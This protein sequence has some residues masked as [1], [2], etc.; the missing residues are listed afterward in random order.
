MSS[1]DDITPYGLELPV[2][3]RLQQRGSGEPQ[4][5]WESRKVLKVLNQPLGYRSQSLR[6]LI[7]KRRLL[8]HH[9]DDFDL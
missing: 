5:R 8:Y 7:F 6:Y 9:H 4:G 1:G 2:T 3:L